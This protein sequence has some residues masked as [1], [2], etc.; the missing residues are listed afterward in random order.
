MRILL[1]NDDGIDA[2][3]I[4]ALR[5]IADELAGPVARY[6]SWRP[7]PTARGAGHSLS[8]NE[9]IRM[10][11]VAERAYAVRGTPTDSIIMATRHVMKGKLPD[12]ILSGINPHTPRPLAT[13][14][15]CQ[16]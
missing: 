9:P 16:S 5:Q 15:S 14:I 11:E 10:R 7:R 6:G 3:G 4:H 12:L 8:L 13:E 2:P 1:S